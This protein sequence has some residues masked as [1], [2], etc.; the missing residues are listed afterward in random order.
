MIQLFKILEDAN[1]SSNKKFQF[2]LSDGE[3]E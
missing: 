1:Y 2:L 3:E